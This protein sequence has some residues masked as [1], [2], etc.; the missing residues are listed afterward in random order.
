M[1]MLWGFKSKREEILMCCGLANDLG[2]YFKWEEMFTKTGFIQTW[3]SPTMQAYRRTVNGSK[4]N[5]ICALCRKLDRF[6]PGSIYPDQRKFFEFVLA[7]STAFQGRKMALAQRH[8]GKR[9]L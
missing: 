9:R 3:N 6:A 5:P 2:V 1:F 7:R 4:V 8:F